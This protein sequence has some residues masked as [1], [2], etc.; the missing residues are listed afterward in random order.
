LNPTPSPV[1]PSK[2]KSNFAEFLANNT[3]IPTLLP[4]I[5]MLPAS[6]TNA[7]RLYKRDT[8]A[9]ATWLV[10]TANNNGHP[11]YQ[12]DEATSGWKG[13]GRKDAKQVVREDKE[14]TSRDKKQPYLLPLR[15]FVPLA[16]FIASVKP[17]I[18]IPLFV[19]ITIDRV[20]EVRSTV[21]RI[22]GTKDE[23]TNE[24]AIETHFHFV[25]VLEQVRDILRPQM[26]TNQALDIPATQITLKTTST[27]ISSGGIGGNKYTSCNPFDILDVYETT[28]QTPDA[29]ATSSP[30]E[31]LV[32]EYEPEPQ[33]TYH[34]ACLAFMSLLKAVLHQRQKVREL[35][36]NY[37]VGHVFLGPTAIGTNEAIN[38]CR[39][40]EDD[41]A[42][43]ISKGSNVVDL[44]TAVFKIM[45]QLEGQELKIPGRRNATNW[46]TYDVANLTMW[47]VGRTLRDIASRNRRD[48][49]DIYNGSQG[50]YDWTM[51]RAS[52]SNRQKFAQD[53]KALLEIISDIRVLGIVSNNKTAE[54]EFTRGVH[55]LL[56]T[57]KVT[58]WQCFAAQI[59][60]DILYELQATPDLAWSEM[61]G[62]S[63]AIKSSLARAVANPGDIRLVD[64]WHDIEQS[65]GELKWAASEW[66][67]DPI[68]RYTAERGIPV[69]PNQFLRR[70]T[71]YCGIWVHEMRTR[72]HEAGVAFASAF[73]YVH[74]T[75]QLYHALRQQKY[76]G[77]TALWKDLEM[78]FKLVSPHLRGCVNRFMSSCRMVFGRILFI[79]QLLTWSLTARAGGLLCGRCP[80]YHPRISR[81]PSPETPAYE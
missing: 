42:S 37:R 34:D 54:D 46:D 72:F 15:R 20:I 71:L 28:D 65:L 50:W 31:E 29:D 80:R 14:A 5:K 55:K 48:S 3:T 10:N 9:I 27:N 67:N 40:M 6:L 52:S 68:A 53:T 36:H 18:K 26:Q 16:N 56:S 81:Q 21:D 12:N 74:Q 57:N 22:M 38:I 62:T 44:L 39:Q 70:H 23:F 4:S 8:N 76:L 59:Y 33:D 32:V 61:A 43:V 19:A 1:S 77:E 35:W 51:D 66:D 11:V 69:G 64:N 49:L 75:Y 63:E 41:V 78:L 45:C 30:S 47:H 2:P 25:V 58:L 73:G 79:I 24:Q 7:V 60:L 17:P 13:K